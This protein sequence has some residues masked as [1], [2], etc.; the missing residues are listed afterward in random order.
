MTSINDKL[1]F[2]RAGKRSMMKLPTD[3]TAR[4]ALTA[5][6]CPQCA[7]RGVKESTVHGRRLRTCSWCGHGWEPAI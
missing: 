5:A 4:N 3:K 6:Q 7:N 1:G 2:K